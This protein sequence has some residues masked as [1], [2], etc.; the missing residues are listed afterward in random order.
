[1]QCAQNFSGENI[2]K[3]FDWIIIGIGWIF[4]GLGMLFELIGI[5]LFSLTYYLD[6]E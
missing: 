2:M 6:E 1:M 3:L 4:L 5:F